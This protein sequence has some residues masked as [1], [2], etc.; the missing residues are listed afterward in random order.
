M[1]R[2]LTL[3]QALAG[4]QP[5][6]LT[7]AEW[8]AMHRAAQLVEAS[9]GHRWS[10]WEAHA[11]GRVRWCARCRMT[12]AEPKAEPRPTP[13]TRPA[14]PPPTAAATMWAAPTSL[15]DDLTPV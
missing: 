2:G 1:N 3:E 10:P 13:L 5:E 4:V 8:D 9:C 6:P 14:A 12:Q 7:R 11:T 15:E